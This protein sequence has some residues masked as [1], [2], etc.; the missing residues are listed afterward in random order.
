MRFAAVDSGAPPLV[1]VTDGQCIDIGDHQGLLA[2]N[3]FMDTRE[4]P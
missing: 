4:L 3:N 1:Y 2:A